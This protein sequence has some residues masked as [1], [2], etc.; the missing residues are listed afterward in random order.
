MIKA[1][2]Y[3]SMPME[4]DIGLIRMAM[5]W[6][7]TRMGIINSLMRMGIEL[8]EICMVLCLCMIVRII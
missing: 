7:R 4:I 1:I 8:K 2:A 5:S 3:K 6:Y